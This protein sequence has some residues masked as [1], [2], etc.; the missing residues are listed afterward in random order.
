MDPRWGLW[1]ACR[2]S[3]M[4]SLSLMKATGYG[5]IKDPFTLTARGLRRE[6]DQRPDFPSRFSHTYQS[7][8]V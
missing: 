7:L 4:I 3:G 6:V 1:D 8:D 5:T 2:C